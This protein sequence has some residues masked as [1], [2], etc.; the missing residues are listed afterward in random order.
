MSCTTNEFPLS[1]LKKAVISL[2]TRQQVTLVTLIP[3]ASYIGLN[4]ELAEVEN[5]PA[6]QAEI[7]HFSLQ[8]EASL[9]ETFVLHRSSSNRVT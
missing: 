3:S 8:V 9:Q 5:A 6:A 1:N 2:A 7:I 4:L